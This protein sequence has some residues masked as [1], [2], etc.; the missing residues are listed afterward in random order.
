MLRKKLGL[1]IA[2]EK[3][4]VRRQTYKIIATWKHARDAA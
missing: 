4:D 1:T 2:S 3:T